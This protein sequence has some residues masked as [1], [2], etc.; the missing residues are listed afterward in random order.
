MPRPASPTRLERWSPALAVVLFGVFWG[1]WGALVGR[2]DLTVM[3]GGAVVAVL[4]TLLVRA[5]LARSRASR[6]R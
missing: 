3:L 5:V 6:T 1:L 4:V 2:P